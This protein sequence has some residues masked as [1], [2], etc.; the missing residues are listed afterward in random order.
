[1]TGIK[2]AW[3]E[4]RSAAEQAAA[5]AP[6][7]EVPSGTSG[8][9]DHSDED[10][11]DAGPPSESDW[12]LGSPPGERELPPLPPL[13]V[14]TETEPGSSGSGNS[15]RDSGSIRPLPPGAL[16]EGHIFFFYL[17]KVQQEN[18]Q[19][20]DDVARF[21]MVLQPLARR[22]PPTQEEVRGGLTE[23]AAEEAAAAATATT[24]AQPPPPSPGEGGE[25][26]QP[27]PAPAPAGP[28]KVG[29]PEAEV[30]VGAPPKEEAG[31]AASPEGHEGTSQ[32]K[33]QG[34]GGDG[35]GGGGGPARRAAAAGPWTVSDVKRQQRAEKAGGE[36]GKAAEA[37]EDEE[38]REEGA[39]GDAGA[40]GP[41]GGGASAAPGRLPCRLIVVG[42][43]RLPDPHRHERFFGFVDAVGD[44]VE[45]LAAGLGAK[46][47]STRTRGE[48]TQPAARAAGR[49]TYS[50]MI[51]LHG[52]RRPST[53]LAYLLQLPDSPGPVQQELG[54]ARSARYVLSIKNPGKRDPGRPVV[55]REPPFSAQQREAF[56]GDTRWVGAE[57]VGLLDVPGAELLL[58]GAREQPMEAAGEAATAH[59]VATHKREIK[60]VATVAAEAAAHASRI[61][62]AEMKEQ[63]QEQEQEEEEEQEE[64]QQKEEQ[65]QKGGTEQE[66]PQHEEEQG[67]KTDGSRGCGASKAR[68]APRAPQGLKPAVRD[69][70]RKRA[71][72]EAATEKAE[73][74]EGEDEGEGAGE[75]EGEG[76]HGMEERMVMAALLRRELAAAAAPEGA[77]QQGGVVTAPAETGEWA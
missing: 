53:Q 24:A 9:G 64:Q 48:R 35:G 72:T 40:A 41:S 4:R 30:E 39:G 6:E 26:H 23:A 15:G 57:D 69:S 42:K 59:L 51:R 13:G 25:G 7:E 11:D 20:L 21:Y 22:P 34:G 29:S 43:K 8:D 68:E 3:R 49:G 10:D 47:Y 67:R 55:V 66:E 36:P 73:E 54:I 18:P 45:Q 32:R 70:G 19:D 14:G 28:R 61:L 37:E 52:R 60:Q 50:I 77:E 71:R 16:E 31:G 76:G 5:D 27:V 75:G 1:M 12:D 58:I 46:H 38:G 63:E 17:P 44:S 62:L 33:E 65:E 56:A 2:R 74:G